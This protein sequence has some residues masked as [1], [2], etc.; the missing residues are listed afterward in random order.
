MNANLARSLG[1][2]LLL[3]ML[4]TWIAFNLHWETITVPTAPKGE[5]LRNPYY[6]LEHFAA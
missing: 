5:A 1:V 4:G 6:A 2:L 3:A